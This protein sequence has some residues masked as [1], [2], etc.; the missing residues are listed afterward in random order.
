RPMIEAYRHYDEKVLAYGPSQ[1]APALRA[2]VAGYYQRLG[3]ALRPE[4]VNVTVG[5]SEALQFALA[6]VGGPRDELVLSQP[7]YANYAGFAKMLGMTVRSVPASAKDG[8][9]LPSD[10]ELEAVIGPRTRAIIFTSPG[11]PTGTVYTPEEMG[12]LGRLAEKHD[13]YLIS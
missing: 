4:H 2:A 1:G 13:L 7:S 12:R 6:A 3:L 10:R 9:H 8:F 5:G 11:N